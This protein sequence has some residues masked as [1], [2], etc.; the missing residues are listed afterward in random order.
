MVETLYII[1]F[2]NPYDGYVTA[3]KLSS[4]GPG[5]LTRKKATENLQTVLQ[6]LTRLCSI[7]GP[8]RR[9]CGTVQR[10]YTHSRAQPIPDILIEFVGGLC[11]TGYQNTWKQACDS[12]TDI[13]DLKTASTVSHLLHNH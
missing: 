4:I 12:Q 10:R 1:H 13:A 11:G 6:R 9:L 2:T 8:G 5:V 3:F 7:S